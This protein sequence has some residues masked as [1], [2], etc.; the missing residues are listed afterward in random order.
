MLMGKKEKKNWERTKNQNDHENFHFIYPTLKEAKSCLS[1]NTCGSATANWPHKHFYIWVDEYRSGAYLKYLIYS[2]CLYTLS[3]KSV[4][5][6]FLFMMKNP[7]T[8]LWL[9]INKI[10]NTQHDPSTSIVYRE[11][12]QTIQS[13]VVLITIPWHFCFYEKKKSII[14]TPSCRKSKSSRIIS[15][16]IFY[17]WKE[18]VLHQ[19]WWS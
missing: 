11:R 12:P 14:P 9:I 2:S 6:F 8:P 13:V 3:F 15:L 17:L 5:V 10:P 4:E 18:N 7:L 19:K 1:S 16:I